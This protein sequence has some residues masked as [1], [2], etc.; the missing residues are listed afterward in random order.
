M[1][2]AAFTFPQSAFLLTLINRAS[3]RVRSVIAFASLAIAVGAIVASTYSG[4]LGGL[5]FGPSPDVERTMKH[6]MAPLLEHS[7]A[8]LGLGA[9]AIDTQMNTARRGHT[10]TL[11]SDGRVLA[12]GGENSSGFVAAAEI[13]DAAT[14]TFSYSGNLST[15]RADHTATL[16]SDGRVLIAG[17]CGDSGPLNSTEIF[18]PATG[19]FAAGPS[20]IGARSGHSATKLGDGRIVLAGGD[21]AGSLEI[22][23]P[24]VNTLAPVDANLGSPRAFHSAAALNDGNILIV[25]GTAPD[26]SPVLSGEVFNVTSLTFTTVANQTQ[27]P[28]VRALLRVLP[29]GKVQIIG[30]TDHENLEL[31]DPAINEF[32]AHAHVY[33]IANSHPELLQ[34]ILDSPTRSALFHLGA[35]SSLVNRTGQTITELSGSNQAL[36]TGGVDSSDTFLISASLLNSCPASITTDRIDYAPGTPVIVTGTGWEPGEVVTLMFHEDP[37]VDTENPHTFSV[38]ADAD[39]DFV[40]Q[41]YAPEAEDRGITY[42]LAAKG[43]RTGWTA[44]TA[45]TDASPGSLGNYATQG[46]SGIT[47]TVAPSN[48]AANVSFSNLTRGVGLAAESA[49]DGFNS[50]SW[51]LTS[52]LTVGGNTDYCEFTIAPNAGFKF[53]ASELR[54]GLQRSGAG[55][56]KAEL[57][58]SLDSYGSTIGSVISVGTGLATFTINLVSISGLQNQTAAVTFRI[59]GYNATSNGG[60]LRI[61]RVA[62]PAMVGLEVDGTVAALNSGMLQF[63]EASFADSET[64]SG[65][66]TKMIT[67]QRIGGSDGSVSV[68]YATSDGTAAIVDNDYDATSGDL[69]WVDGDTADQTFTV[70]VNGD[71]T[72]EGDETFNL[73]LSAPT[74][75]ATISGTNPA[76]L[77]ITNDDAQPAISINDVITDEGNT[78]TTS[79]DFMV[80]LS[81]PSDQTVTVEY[82]TADDTASATD[83]TAV[84]TTTVTFLPGETTK[85]VT[86]LVNGDNVFEATE[87]FFVNLSNQT[88][89][90][91]PD[92]QGV[93]TIINEDLMPTISIGHKSQAEVNAGS[94]NFD[95]ALTLSNPSDQTISVHYTAADGT[96]AQ[97]QDYTTTSGKVIFVPNDTSET[98]SVSVNGDTTFESN[99]TFF[100]NLHTPTN[101]TMLDAQGQGTI[102]NDDAQPTVQFSAVNSLGSESVSPA[103]LQVT[104]SNPSDQTITVNY[105]ATGGTATGGGTDYTLV[106]GALQFN[107]GDTS[108][109]LSIT[110]ND[111]LLDENDE[112][113]VV[114]LS[115]P[116][117]ATLS[118]PASHTY[119]IQDNDAAPTFTINDVTMNEGNAGTTDFIFTVT[120]TGPTA[121]VALV[122]YATASGTTNPP[123]DDVACVGGTDYETKSGTL[124]FAPAD[125]TMIVTIKVC[126]DITVEANETFFVNLSGATNAV[127]GDNQVLGSITNDD[128]APS[129]QIVFS[130][131]RDGNFE[132][133]KMSPDGS[134]I[135]RLTHNSAVDADAAWSP[136]RTK[137][138]F[139]STRAGNFE[140]YVMNADGS[141]VMRLTT[142]SSIDFF[143]TWSPDGS[144]I[145]FTSNR[146]G[147][148][149][150]YV[151]NSSGTGAA[152]RL[153]ANCVVDGAAAWSPN[154]NKIAF[155]SRRDGNYEIYVMNS[156]G[157][158]LTRLTNHGAIDAL[159][160]WAPDGLSIAFN[161]TRAGNLEIYTMA[162]DGS[163]QTRRTTTSAIDGEPSWGANGRIAFSSTRNG[164]L[165]IYTMN[166]DGTGVSRLTN[167]SAWD[168]SPHW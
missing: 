14:G 4:A 86:V 57:R 96:A 138:V 124:T 28:H 24:L 157:T 38:Q 10:A 7:A 48:V 72:Y 166:A 162:A 69:T 30:G 159:P 122:N 156:N 36:V 108:E 54:V 132:I 111:D 8:P 76:T 68:H 101:A 154:G 1:V 17:G 64:N 67:V 107:P 46:L 133:Y 33:P 118:S 6:P 90:T 149:E 123:T 40:H 80:T 110:V 141:G 39:G 125:T 113:V 161:S 52:S 78:G 26:G 145:A 3:M 160:S 99:E 11:L 65:S 114:D 75:D 143:P 120:K 12:V 79:Y 56:A 106:N 152:T 98:V 87:T 139:S 93:G 140:I 55:P 91:L 146:N 112:T 15:P 81:N 115:A 45:F 137:I 165:E 95:F 131:N 53:N 77:A 66:H 22:Y 105:G 117:H 51:P 89:A 130:S 148:F 127:I 102:E 44:Q 58:S 9:P 163:G 74:G 121:L 109:N 119:T 71:T 151:M 27:D 18:D 153:T 167:N 94:S 37:H 168:V 103:N 34:E 147:N 92:S 47:T 50:S 150:V 41:E 128:S 142:T 84:P 164:N 83:Y 136:D 16:L 61:Q 62:S 135:V 116:T 85:Q 2:K 20:M 70:T 31:Y 144:K 63:S 23:D 155:T 88:N 134:G 100:V 13:F 5:F 29:D 42:I 82:A 104:L 59:Y 32:G 25:G 35:S 97:P 21:T 60:T 73:T 19:A 43:E 158:G 126:G 49:A 129:A